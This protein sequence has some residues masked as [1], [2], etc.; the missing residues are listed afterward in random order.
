MNALENIPTTRLEKIFAFLG[1]IKIQTFC[2]IFHDRVS[3]CP[4]YPGTCSI[5]QTGLEPRD[6]PTC[7]SPVPSDI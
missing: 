1:H 3:L 7:A 6:L 5:D 4:C 2:F